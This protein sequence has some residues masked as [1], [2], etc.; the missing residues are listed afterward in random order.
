FVA[1]AD[2]S[3]G[4]LSEFRPQHAIVLNVDEEHLDFYASLEAVCREFSKFGRQAQGS[5][6]FCADDPRLAELFARQPGAVSYGFHPLAAYRLVTKGRS[7]TGMASLQAEI[8]LRVASHEA[9]EVWHAG[10]KLGEF[11]LRLIGDKNVSNAGA[12]I[13]LLHQLG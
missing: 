8:G 10:N 3:D 2:E 11:T 5:L 7:P 9:F 4:T 13:A 12:V 1:E 6:I